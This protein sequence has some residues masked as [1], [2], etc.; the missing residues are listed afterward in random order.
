MI[1]EEYHGSLPLSVKNPLLIGNHRSR[2]TLIGPSLHS[3]ESDTRRVGNETGIRA[4]SL[5]FIRSMHPNSLAIDANR[6]CISSVCS[7][8][9]G[10][11]RCISRVWQPICPPQRP[12]RRLKAGINRNLTGAPQLPS[13]QLQ[14]DRSLSLSQ[15]S[16]AV[17]LCHARRYAEIGRDN[18]TMCAV[19]A[20]SCWQS[21][22]E[23]S[24][25]DI[26]CRTAG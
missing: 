23:R 8:V 13:S 2:L 7:T 21:A 17:R 19:C 15:S 16:V 22:S 11:D 26:S 3:S 25:R 24:P 1:V 4:I 12:S 18:N 5:A 10:S 14:S 20:T 6:P 9:D